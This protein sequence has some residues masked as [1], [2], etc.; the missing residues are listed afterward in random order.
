MELGH[1]I[2]D[3]EHGRLVRVPRNPRRRLGLLDDH[4]VRA[5]AREPLALVTDP[6]GRR[7]GLAIRQRGGE[8]AAQGGRGA[9][10]G[11][12][13]VGRR[14]GDGGGGGG[15]GLGPFTPR[16]TGSSRLEGIDAERAIATFAVPDGSV[17]PN[18]QIGWSPFG[19]VIVTRI[20]DPARY[21]WPS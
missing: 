18:D 15:G 17:S 11:C 1:A 21:T 9:E 12:G 16:T 4:D 8:M 5:R 20:R 10:G 6:R 14:G 3:A 19:A 7:P 2:A 13:G